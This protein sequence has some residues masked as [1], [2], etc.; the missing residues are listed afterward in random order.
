MKLLRK[1]SVLNLPK[2]LDY[3]TVLFV[4]FRLFV[5]RTYSSSETRRTQWRGRWSTW[6][7]PKWSTQRTNPRWC[8][9]RT[10]SAWSANIEGTYCRLCTRRRSTTGCTPSTRSWPARSGPSPPDA[11]PATRSCCPT[12]A[13]TTHS[14]CPTNEN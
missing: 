11:T 3:P 8:V 7:R 1:Q 13:Q 5:V 12:A 6:L 2:F 10:R 4:N 9:Y 14:P